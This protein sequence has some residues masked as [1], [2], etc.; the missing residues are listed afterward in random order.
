MHA[1][2]IADSSVLAALSGIGY[3]TLL[4][5]IWG[6]VAI[7]S[8][9]RVEVVDQGAGWLEARDVQE[10]ILRGEWIE[11]FEVNESPALAGLREKLGAGESECIELAGILRVPLLVDDLKA[12]KAAEG[13]GISV[14]GTLGA[15]R[16]AKA[17]GLIE[18]ARPLIHSMEE[19]GIFMARRV[20]ERFLEDLGEGE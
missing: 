18:R 17:L 3:L 10:E 12:R 4:R 7:P 2:V 6:V 8:A 11:T 20:I 19:N 9:V 14:T 15:I 1:K 13:M 16:R 5:G